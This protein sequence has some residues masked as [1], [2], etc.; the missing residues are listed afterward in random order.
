MPNRE[1]L[2]TALIAVALVCTG[3]LGW[4]LQLRPELVA[5]PASLATLPTRLG[6]WRG[7]AIPLEAGVESVLRADA[8]VQRAYR[9]DV[10]R[11]LVWLYVGYYGTARGGRPEHTPRGCYTG[12]G[13][14]ILDSQTLEGSSTAPAEEGDPA[15]PRVHEYRVGRE[16]EERL[17]HFWYR[18]HRRTGMVGGLDQNLDR[19]AGRLFDGRADGALIRLSTPLDDPDELDAARRRLQNLAGVLDDQIAARW[20]DER[21]ASG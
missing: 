7:E 4:W 15:S 18:S 20:P 10:T 2:A 6:D 21:P 13:W 19:L 12:A 1:S 17:V 14:A 9:H 8:N 5:D 3:A 11:E 16:G